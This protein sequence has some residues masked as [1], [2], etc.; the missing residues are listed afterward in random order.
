MRNVKLSAFS[1]NLDSKNEAKKT[2]DDINRP[3]N[4]SRKPLHR[5]WNM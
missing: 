1:Y 5:S 4:A 2:I 3:G